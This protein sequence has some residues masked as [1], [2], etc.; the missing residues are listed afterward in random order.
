[1]R[2]VV[3]LAVCMLLVIGC[4]GSKG[5]TIDELKTQVDD[6]THRVKLLE[7]DLL[8]ADKQLIQQQQAMQQLHEEMRN[9]ENYFNKLQAGQSSVR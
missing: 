1:M 3:C 8:K 9:M 6:L 7:D 5:K 2:T 4:G